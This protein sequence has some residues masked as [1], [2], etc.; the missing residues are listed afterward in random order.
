MNLHEVYLVILNCTDYMAAFRV[1]QAQ[2]SLHKRDVQFLRIGVHGVLYLRAG[3]YIKGCKE[4]FTALC[5]VSLQMM[6]VVPTIGLLFQ[7][8][9]A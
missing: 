5:Y 9:K 8:P 6:I 4:D 2:S 3:Y 7:T 1:R